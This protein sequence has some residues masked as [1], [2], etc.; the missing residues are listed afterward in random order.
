MSAALLG[1]SKYILEMKA[2]NKI[3]ER[4]FYIPTYASNN[5]GTLGQIIGGTQAEGN[6]RLFLG[7]G[8]RQVT[9]GQ[10]TQGAGARKSW[11]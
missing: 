11:G 7:S 6:Q 9:E 2:D 10:L 5:G 4:N 3:I 1:L 8:S